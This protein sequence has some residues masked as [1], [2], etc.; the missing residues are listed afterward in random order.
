[1]TDWELLDERP[2]SAGFIKLTTRTYRQP[3]GHTAEWDIVGSGRTVAVVAFTEDRDVIL[4]RQFRPGPGLL[5]DELPGGAVDPGEEVADGAARELLEETGY[6]GDIKVVGSSWFASWSVIQRYA[7]VATSCRRVGKPAYDDG[8][9]CEVVTMTV[10]EFREHLRRGEL[11]DVDVGYQAFD[12][13]GL[14]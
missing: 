13:L 14:L 1:M 2:G 6:V 12:A 3:D 9:F 5:L 4:V 11:T 8:E 7:V 10:A